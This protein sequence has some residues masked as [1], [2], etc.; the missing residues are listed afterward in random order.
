MV[1]LR[2]LLFLKVSELERAWPFF[3]LYLLLFCAFSVA[4][5]VSVA[6]FIKQVGAG[7]L[8]FAYSLTAIANLILIGG[9]VLWTER[10]GSTRMFYL[11]VGGSA[12]AYACAWTALRWLN[13][14]EGW[15]YVLFV[16]REIGYT[17]MLMHFGTFLQD[18]FTRDQL[19]RVLPMIYAGGR[20]GGIAGGAMLQHLSGPLGALDII[21]I[22][23]A[24]C[25]TCLIVVAILS[26]WI[27]PASNQSPGEAEVSEP[28]A[29]ACASVGGFLDFVWQSPL[30][31]WMTIS[32]VLYMVIRWFLNYQ[33]TR[34]FEGHFDTSSDLTEFLGRY[35]QWAL[36]LSLVLQLLVVSRLV[37]WL[38]LGKTY[39]LFAAVVGL[40]ALIGMTPMTLGLAMLYRFVETELR[41]G[42][43]NPL[44]QLMSNQFAKPL[45]IRVR[46]WTMGF[47]TPIATML[48]SMALGLL[49]M[50]GTSAWIAAIGGVVGLVHFFSAVKMHAGLQKAES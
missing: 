34:F 18:H 10:I 12:C 30:L 14:G 6:L 42:V 2:E 39:L 8:P 45:R 35:T 3:L 15:Y 11:I 23:L 31:F 5:G 28:E 41:F 50:T 27:P 1:K 32:S 22:F 46:A 7:H 24:L 43:R 48:S 26:F 33:Y 40:S 44:M 4:D 29:A 49:M 17:L 16:T 13:G 25:V 9:Y 36:L 47:L 20:V 19:V 21:P 38:G 37:A